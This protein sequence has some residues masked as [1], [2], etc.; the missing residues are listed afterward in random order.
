MTQCHSRSMHGRIRKRG[1][2]LCQQQQGRTT[3]H[4]ITFRMGYLCK[5]VIT[6]DMEIQKQPR[7]IQESRRKRSR[8]PTINRGGLEEDDNNNN[9][10][11]SSAAS[12]SSS[13]NRVVVLNQLR[14]GWSNNNNNNNYYVSEN[15]ASSNNDRSSSSSRSFI[16]Y[17]S[18]DVEQLGDALAKRDREYSSLFE[19][20]SR[21][22]ASYKEL[23]RKMAEAEKELTFLRSEPYYYSLASSSSTPS[24]LGSGGGGGVVYTAPVGTQGRDALYWHRLCRTMEMQYLQAKGEADEKTLRLISLSNRI[25]ELEE[26]R[27]QQRT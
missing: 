22:L 27:K 11:S 8:S 21:L 19:L 2:E 15:Y 6:F 1:H 16:S 20:N 4:D 12:S 13:S 5:R 9:P 3:A 18:R 17:N 26:E 7:V 14:R 10:V 23:E 25:K 24:C